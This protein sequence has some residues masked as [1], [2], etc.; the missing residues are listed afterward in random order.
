MFSDKKLELVKLF[1]K[2]ANNLDITQIRDDK[3]NTVLHQCAF[4]GNV[5]TMVC[6]T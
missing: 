6:Y 3:Q 5:A 2:D 4:Q 1:L